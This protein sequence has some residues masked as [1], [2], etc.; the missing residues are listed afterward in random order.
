MADSTSGNSS[1]DNSASRPLPLGLAGRVIVY[2]SYE[3]RESTNPRGAGQT[4]EEPHYSVG[5]INEGLLLK[6][7]AVSLCLAEFE[8]LNESLV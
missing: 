3:A 5:T 6:G 2:R 4:P 7:S 8:S 1:D